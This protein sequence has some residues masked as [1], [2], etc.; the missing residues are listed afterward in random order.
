MIPTPPTKAKA[1]RGRTIR[2]WVVGSEQEQLA[3]KPYMQIGAKYDPHRTKADRLGKAGLL[4]RGFTFHDVPT[5]QTF[6]PTPPARDYDTEEDRAIIQE[7]KRFVRNLE[8]WVALPR[9]QDHKT[10]YDWKDSCI[11]PWLSRMDRDIDVSEA[12][13]QL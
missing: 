10:G 9:H 6:T 7:S 12:I 13:A 1:T 3:T 8:S 11:P 4:Q 2:G 5:P